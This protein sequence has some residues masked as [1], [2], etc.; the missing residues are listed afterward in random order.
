MAV[1]KEVEDR[2]EIKAIETRFADI[3]IVGDT[4]LLV[5]AWDPKAKQMMLDNQMGKTKTKARPK[6]DPYSDFMGSLYWITERPKDNTPVAFYEAVRNGARFGFQ[7]TAIKKAANSAAYRMGWVSNQT[8]LRGSYY[9]F[10]D[11]DPDIVEVKG[12]IPEMREDMVAIKGT[13]DIRFRGEF[14]NW[15]ID[16]K[17]KYNANGPISLEQIL[18]C[19]NAGGFAVGIGEWRPE[20]NGTHG[21]YHV[22]TETH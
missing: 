1:K 14:K 19:I 7:A 2:I 12:C 4:P 10:G 6:K 17:I 16:L 13:T 8:T 18:N 11:D 5:H 9:I 3:R 21:M 22:E 20:K 15:Y